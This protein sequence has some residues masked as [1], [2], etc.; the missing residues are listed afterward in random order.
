MVRIGARIRGAHA[1]PLLSFA[2]LVARDAHAQ[3][4]PEVQLVG[5]VDTGLLVSSGDT[6][7]LAYSSSGQVY[8][9]QSLDQG[10]T[11][12]AAMPIARGKIHYTD[13]IAVDGSDVYVAYLG[14]LR[15]TTTFYGSDDVGN[16]YV[17]H[18]GDAGA[19]WD[20]PC[21]LT[22]SDDV[23]RLSMDTSSARVDVVWSNYSNP[24][25]GQIYYRTSPSRGACTSW[26]SV[27]DLDPGSTSA[28]RPQ[29][30]DWGNYV[31]IVWEAADSGRP[32]CF[33]LPSCPDNYYVRSTNGGASF[34]PV[35]HITSYPATAPIIGRVEI[36]VLPPSG[37]VVFFYQDLAPNQVLFSQTSAANGA[38][39]SWSSPVQLTDLPGTNNHPAAG[40]RAAGSI[41]LVAWTNNGVAADGGTGPT[42][43]WFSMSS[44][45]AQMWS[46]P[47][48]VSTQ[49][50]LY[51]NDV[52]ATSAWAHVVYNA[53]AGGPLYYRRRAL[54]AIAGDAGVDA[55]SGSSSGGGVP[56][57]GGTDAGA[58]LVDASSGAN[59]SSGGCGCEAAGSTPPRAPLAA[60]TGWPALA[61]IVIRRRRRGHRV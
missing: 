61:M 24:N 21:Q 56:D 51:A 33:S 46:P 19:T 48:Q 26:S 22:T 57:A 18:S 42:T 17:V 20:A 29:L 54:P 41:A 7:H 44:P 27:V 60:V 53:F 35:Q 43:P 1:A 36:T 40:A 32:P 30:A 3:W 25:G 12:T 4:A 16:L 47:E 11:W 9:R 58:P 10:T 6:L 8:Y 45:G 23:F 38:S 37:T 59:G 34:E 13:P 31:H 15:Q 39:G 28:T 50:G 5:A 55:D 49:D 14:D 52:A 2:L